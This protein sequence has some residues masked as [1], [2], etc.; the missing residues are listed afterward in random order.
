[1]IISYG[2]FKAYQLVIQL[3]SMNYKETI[4]INLL[5]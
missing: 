4:N 1:M 2:K 5:I 3:L